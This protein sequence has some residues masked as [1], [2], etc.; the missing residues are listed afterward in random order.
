MM[1]ANSHNLIITVKPANQRTT[2]SSLGPRRGSYSRNSNLSHGSHLS[3]S[4]IHSNSGR[5]SP[6]GVANAHYSDSGDHDDEDEIRD[7]TSFTK[8]EFASNPRESTAY[9]STGSN[10]A[11]NN[12]KQ[13][14]HL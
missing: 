8:S 6:G 1:V 7:L 4:S 3:R 12:R 11:N 5:D 9:G 10:G 13:V 14:L 2:L